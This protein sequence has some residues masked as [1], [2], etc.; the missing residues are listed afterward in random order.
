MRRTKAKKARAA[1]VRADARHEAAHA[2]VSVRLGLPLASTDIAKR[3]VTSQFGREGFASAGYTAIEPGSA[4]RWTSELPADS[5]RANLEAFA[6][7]AGAGVVAELVRGGELDDPAHRGD[8]QDIVQIAAVLG[9]GESSNDPA[10]RDFMT[11]SIKRA[12]EALDRDGGRAWDIIT[13][14]LMEKKALTGD[15]VR[16]LIQYADDQAQPE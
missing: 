11:R 3:T 12:G 16:Y 8:L 15:Q 13:E 7:Q 2:V 1:A 14:A 9:L 5:A 4:E 6:A 10:I